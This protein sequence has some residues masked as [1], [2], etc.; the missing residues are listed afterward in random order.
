MAKDPSEGNR[1]AEV[2]DLQAA[3]EMRDMI[4]PASDNNN[5]KSTIFCNITP[6]L[7]RQIDRLLTS[8]RYPFRSKGDLI[9]WCVKTGVDRLA[10]SV[11]EVGDL[12]IQTNATIR[13]LQEREYSRVMAAIIQSMSMEVSLSTK[14]GDLVEARRV[15][16]EIRDTLSKI[17]DKRWRNR[18]MREIDAKFADLLSLPGASLGSFDE[19]DGE[20]E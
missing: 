8:N 4:I 12:N 20:V 14:E 2:V 5:D 3:R 15:V 11:P 1:P 10:A 16:L 6:A 18:Y 17:S 7:N 13:L 9:R 19:E